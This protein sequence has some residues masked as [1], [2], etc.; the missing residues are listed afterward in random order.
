MMW[1]F[2]Y[3]GVF[4]LRIARGPVCPDIEFEGLGFRAQGRNKSGFMVRGGRVGE[5]GGVGASG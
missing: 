2:L 1:G 3:K 4:L 5:L